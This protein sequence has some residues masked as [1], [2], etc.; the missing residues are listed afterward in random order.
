MET[1]ANTKYKYKVKKR[2]EK[3]ERETRQH[4]GEQKNLTKK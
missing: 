3:I 4:I 1:S 2:E